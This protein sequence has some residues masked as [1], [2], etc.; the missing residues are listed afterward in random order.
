MYIE[1][2]LNISISI[3]TY[4]Y[5]YLDLDL[6]LDANTLIPNT[7]NIEVGNP[8]AKENTHT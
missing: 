2:Q 3:Y 4:I 7:H 8:D 5:I 1:T 6:D